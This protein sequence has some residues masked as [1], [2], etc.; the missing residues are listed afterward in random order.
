MYRIERLSALAL[1]ALNDVIEVKPNYP[2]GDDNQ[3]T[4]TAP[5]GKPD[6][7]CFY[8]NYNAICEVTMLSDRSQWFSEGQPVMRHLRDFSD[9]YSNKRTYCIFIAPRLH[10][11]TLETFWTAIKYGYRGQ[12]QFIVPLTVTQMAELLEILVDFRTSGISLSHNKLSELW[13]SIISITDEV[14]DSARWT[15]EIP[16]KIAAWREAITNEERQD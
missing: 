6:I 16:S 11:D 2:V 4:F 9:Q 8:E 14:E 15:F 12:N 3:P 13:D 1:N 5:A 10:Q 7:E